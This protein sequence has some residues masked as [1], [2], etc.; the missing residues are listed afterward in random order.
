MAFWKKQRRSSSSLV[1]YD[2]LGSATLWSIHTTV[3]QIDFPSTNKQSLHRATDLSATTLL[4]YR[5]SSQRVF[6]LTGLSR[7]LFFQRRQHPDV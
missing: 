7:L 1:L 6:I 5:K 4:R 3:V 2:S